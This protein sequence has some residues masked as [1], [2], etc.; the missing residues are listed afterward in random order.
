MHIVRQF[1]FNFRPA[2]YGFGATPATGTRVVIARIDHPLAKDEILLVAERWSGRWR[3]EFDAPLDWELMP[4]RISSRQSLTF[5]ELI[6]SFEKTTIEGGKLAH[7]LWPTNSD[8]FQ[9][10]DHTMSMAEQRLRL[11][12]TESFPQ[13]WSEHYP[14]LAPWCADMQTNW[15]D[16]YLLI[17]T[18]M[19]AKS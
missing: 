12:R 19:R 17:I 18:E 8:F 7:L 10:T 9:S 6:E 11:T 5:G 3:Y 2:H 4:G 13:A 1:D 14:D 15:I 16:R